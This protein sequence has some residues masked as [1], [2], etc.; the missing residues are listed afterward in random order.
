MFKQQKVV[1]KKKKQ[2]YFKNMHE[3]SQ[4]VIGTATRRM[5]RVNGATL[6][7]TCISK[8]TLLNPLYANVRLA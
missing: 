5:N 1:K 6:T 3:Q 4:R 8:E 7:K 2:Q